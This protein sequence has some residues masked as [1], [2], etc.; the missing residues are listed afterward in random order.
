MEKNNF[1]CSMYLCAIAVQ[2]LSSNG[3]FKYSGSLG[4]ATIHKVQILTLATLNDKNLLGQT[5]IVVLCH[6]WLDFV[7]IAIRMN[8]RYN[9]SSSKLCQKIHLSPKLI[10]SL[11]QNLFSPHQVV[12]SHCFQVTMEGMVSRC[13]EIFLRFPM[14]EQEVLP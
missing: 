4:M 3:S 11:I 13:W 12:N 10:T 8:I 7:K 14:F 6:Y 2:W 5:I 1:P 9:H